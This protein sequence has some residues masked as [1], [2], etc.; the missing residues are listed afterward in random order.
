VIK[1]PPFSR[2]D[3]ISCRNLLIYLNAELQKKLIPLF[4][5]ALNP[6]GV[7]FLGTSETVGEFTTLF[8]VLDRKWRLYLRQED[9]PG[10]ARPA[11]GDFGPPWR[12]GRAQ[13]QPLRAEAR[14]NLR[15]LAERTLL[16][17]YAPAGVLVNGHGEIR[18]IYG[19]TGQYLEPTPGDAGLNIL[20]MAREGLRRPLTTALHKAV[21]GKEPVHYPGLR[22]KTNGE[23]ITVHLT[24]RPVASS[25]GAAVPD[26]FLVILEGAPP[27]ERT[28]PGPAAAEAVGDRG[29]LAS[30]TEGRIAALEQ[31]LQ[32]KEE[33]LQ[34]TL[35]EMETANEE[36][37]STNE[38]M[39]SVNEELQSTNEE[40]ETSK[41]ELQSLNE[42]LATVNA[43]LQTKV[44]DL[45]R[46]NNDMNNLLAGTGVGTLFV[47][48]HLRIFRFTPAATAVIN[49]IQTDVGRPL[50]HVVS[51]LVGYD[52]LV[53]DV[54]T[55]LDSLVPFQAEVQTA[56]GAWYLLGIRPYR[57]VENVIEGAVITFVEITEMKR[58]EEQVRRLATVVRDSNDAITVQDFEGNI[59]AWN[60][61]AERIYGWSE[62]EALEMNVCAIVP[63][64]KRQEALAFVEQIDRGEPVASFQT[65]RVTK[66]GRV[67]DIWMTSTKLVNDAGEPYAIATTERNVTEKGQ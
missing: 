10:A 52:H 32:A 31:E 11:P 40:L 66:D 55:V 17:H 24:V 37:T 19:R 39:Q 62:A 5:Y 15:E 41:E 49:L 4:H 20:A 7:L 16:Q 64:D 46:A 6:Q 58:M 54:Q 63:E 12:E 29:A 56:A 42:E 35:E 45:T 65:Q 60:P 59:L 9:L 2:L 26:L 25:P 8:Q 43:E 14:V 36:L 67:L 18:H 50:G 28:L 47:D 51:N 23:F 57:T 34:T 3:L 21:A 1:D 33:Y 30:D 13:A 61:G 22:V 44:A 53:Q 27:P 38:E 48:L